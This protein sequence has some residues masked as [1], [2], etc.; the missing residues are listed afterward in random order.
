MALVAVPDENPRWSSQEAGGGVLS[1]V[2][3]PGDPPPR[4]SGGAGAHSHS[5]EERPR[6]HG[7]VRLKTSGSSGSPNPR[8]RDA[9]SVVLRQS[10]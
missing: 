1:G 6:L 9:S 7:R 4:G 10:W 8:L 3:G 2:H 5:G